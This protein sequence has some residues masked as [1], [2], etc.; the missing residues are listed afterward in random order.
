MNT[1]FSA[2]IS[3]DLRLFTARGS[4]AAVALVF[5][6]V[7]ASLFP[8]ALAQEPGLLRKS[9]A[10]IV[11]VAALLASL[12]SLDQ[13]YLRD[14]EDG[15]LDLL[16]MSGVT[17]FRLAAAKM[18]SHWLLAGAP[19]AAASFIVSIML[20]VPPAVTGPIALSLALGTLY[21]SLLGGAGAA[22]VL[23][24]R[25]SGLLLAILVLPLFVP[26]LILGVMAGAAALAD[27]PY[28]AY[29]LLQLA[30]VVAALPV[31]PALAGQ[32]FNLHLRSS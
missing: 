24:S 9:A 20:D 21:L 5:F 11:W 18:T 30:L 22:L 12:L 14:A 1:A 32:F 28:Q 26:M 4:E 23:G 25:R 27:A 15:T 29:L 16:L 31:A 13:L 17:P 8:F 6:A 10:G 3:R 19:L 7:I 2:M